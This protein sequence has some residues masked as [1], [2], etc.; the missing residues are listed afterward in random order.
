MPLVV[1]LMPPRHSEKRGKAPVPW[2]LPPRIDDDDIGED[3]ES[4]TKSGGPLRV[5]PDGTQVSASIFRRIQKLGLHDD[6]MYVSG[7]RRTKSND[8][9]SSPRMG[10]EK[11]SYGSVTILDS[12]SDGGDSKGDDAR[13]G[14]V[15]FAKS[16]RSNRS[17]IDDTRS[18]SSSEGED[19][20]H[21]PKYSVWKTPPKLDAIEYPEESAKVDMVFG[22]ETFEVES[23]KE[24]NLP[25]KAM[26]FDAPSLAG[27]SAGGSSRDAS[28]KSSNSSASS[29][30]K[31][32]TEQKRL[33]EYLKR[34]EEK[35]RKKGTLTPRTAD[36]LPKK[37]K[38]EDLDV[39]DDDDDLAFTPVHVSW[40]DDEKTM[41]ER[42]P[43]GMTL[44]GIKKGVQ[45]SET[46]ESADRSL[47]NIPTVHT[48]EKAPSPPGLSRSGSIM[49]LK[50]VGSTMGQKL[51]RS[52]SIRRARSTTALNVASVRTASVQRSLKSGFT[53]DESQR[54]SF[55]MKGIL[56]QAVNHVASTCQY[57]F[58]MQ[59][60]KRHT[61]DK[62]R[63]KS[64][65]DNLE[66]SILFREQLKEGGRGKRV[67]VVDLKASRKNRGNINYSE[68]FKFYK[69]LVT[70]LDIEN[71]I[72]K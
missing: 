4:A 23:P 66:M 34:L 53:G 2:P 52:V 44:T 32:K 68:M 33:E 55:V 35:E 49:N 14:A 19:G 40:K 7:H 50:R 38:F 29:G 3:N 43:F 69:N 41:E 64:V 28:R 20:M 70:Q 16:T 30:L 21:T 47:D 65:E 63:V 24:G 25:P 26:L 39:E 18:D 56:N 13:D 1:S 27:L 48:V 37:L 5:L 61:N 6:D 12:D 62:L 45:L 8:E 54:M 31:S 57:H 42:N 17:A 60:S 72:E 36:L 71:F 67:T 46:N 15:H 22:I 11:T 59:V 58:K 10:Q 9:L 51:K